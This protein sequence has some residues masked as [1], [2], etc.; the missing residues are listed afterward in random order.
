MSS[1]EKQRPMQR[2]PV[3]RSSKKIS[4]ENQSEALKKSD[5]L[6]E[7]LREIY[8]ETLSEPV[9]DRFRELLREL[10]EK[11]EKQK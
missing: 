5:W 4:A 3:P 7:K 9:P 11:A 2:K 1:R 10:D 6:G 8:D